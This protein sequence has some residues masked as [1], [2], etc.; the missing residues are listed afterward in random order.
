MGRSA[1]LAAY[2]RIVS[3]GLLGDLQLKVYSVLFHNG[4]M[5]QG[6]VWSVFFPDH[7]R[8]SIA[9][10]FAE[11]ERVGVVRAVGDRPCRV[12]GYNAT[13]W[14]VTENLPSK[15]PK[16]ETEPHGDAALLGRIGAIQEEV[17]ALKSRMAALE[18]KQPSVMQGEL[19][20]LRSH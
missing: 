6:E 15:S 14:D 13:L 3:D 18:G 16:P 9:P 12:T 7:Q 19:F 2:Q 20:S 10:R 5:T 11:L 4:P 1:S 8:H 17:E